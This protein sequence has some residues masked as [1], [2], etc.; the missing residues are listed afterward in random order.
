M[1]GDDVKDCIGIIP[2][3]LIAIQGVPIV[4]FPSGIRGADDIYQALGENSRD[5][6]DIDDVIG[7]DGRVLGI[8]FAPKGTFE[9]YKITGVFEGMKDNMKKKFTIYRSS[10]ECE[11]LIQKKGVKVEA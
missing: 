11:P 3:P 7:D 1:T 10:G 8:I 4:C 6:V 9:A 5:E 2:S